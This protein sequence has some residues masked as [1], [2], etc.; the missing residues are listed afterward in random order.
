MLNR[1]IDLNQRKVNND[2]CIFCQ[3]IFEDLK[4][5]S[6]CNS[7]LGSLHSNHRYTMNGKKYSCVQAYYQHLDAENL[8]KI[9]EVKN[10]AA[11]L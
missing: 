10:N 2:S 9:N 6:L 3:D 5:K 1:I 11:A 8:T 7:S 4:D